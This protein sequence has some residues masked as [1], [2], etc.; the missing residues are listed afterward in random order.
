MSQEIGVLGYTLDAMVADPDFLVHKRPP[1]PP[2]KTTAYLLTRFRP[3]FFVTTEAYEN[4][5]PR[6]TYRFGLTSGV[7][8]C[9]RLAKLIRRHTA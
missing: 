9:F 8:A 2:E 3:A 4:G 6:A 7:A 1:I 5:A